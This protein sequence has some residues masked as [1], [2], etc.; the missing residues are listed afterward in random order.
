MMRRKA[1]DYFTGYL[2]I[3]PYV[4]GAFML[5][6]IPACMSLYYSFTRFKVISPPMFNGLDNIRMLLADQLFM[7]AF[8]NT[9]Y[10]SLIYVPIQVVIPLVFAVMLSYSKKLIRGKWSEWLRAIYY[11]PAIPSWFVIGMVWIWLLAPEIGIVN[12]IIGW[13]G[14]SDIAFLG[15]GSDSI[16]PS[17]ALVAVWKGLGYAMFIYFIGL[18]NIPDSLYESAEIDGVNVWQRFRNITVPMISPTTFL[19]V[20]ISI[21][22][23]FQA[24]DQHFTMVFNRY[25]KYSDTHLMVY[26]YEKAFRFMDMGYASLI[27]WVSFLC[28]IIVTLIV[29][30]LQK[31]W[32]HYEE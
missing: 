29:L 15:I 10:Y 20:I 27:A 19:I 1:S 32:V 22:S 8:K 9:W 18:N 28:M 2:F 30:F 14:K 4:I 17:L 26:L 16:I 23:A 24:F 31:R 21:S 12:Q 3:M 25:N 7:T 13:F 5:F 6:I 11:F